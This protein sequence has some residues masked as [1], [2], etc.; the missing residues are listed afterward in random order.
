MAKRN[1]SRSRDT[2]RSHKKTQSQI[3]VV[4]KSTSNRTRARDQK[5][6]RDLKRK[7]RIRRISLGLIGLFLVILIGRTIS[8][9]LNTYKVK[10]YP[11][12]R[13][14]V[15]DSMGSDV[16]IA[17]SEGR[18]LSTAEKVTDFDN[19]YKIIQRNYAV[20]SNNI[21]DFIEF[22]NKYNDFRKK[23][24]I[25]KTDQE[26]L[27][28][29]NQYLDVLDDIRTFIIDKDT[30]DSLFNFH[31][32]QND[33]YRRSV[34]ENPQAVDRYKRLINQSNKRKPSMDISIEKEQILRISLPDFKPD[35]FK[36]DIKKINEALT[37]GQ[38]ITTILLDLSDNDSIDDVYKNKLLEILIHNDYKE[39]N[40]VF[41]RGKLADTTLSSIK[42]SENNYY[43]T[44]HVKNDARKYANDYES[45]NLDDY[46]YYD[47]LSLDIKKD[48]EYSNR[49]IYVLTN[50]NTA[51][52]AI[53]LA[54]IL[55]QNGAYVVKNGFDTTTTYKEVIYNMPSELYV[56]EHS[57]LVLSLNAAYSKNEEDNRYL[58][59][60]QKINSKD[61]IASMLNI[62]N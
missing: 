23:V 32:N 59:Y 55:K 18:S 60:D 54:D 36:D 2:S 21:N 7:Y 11:E 22:T 43:S 40:L 58:T 3:R 13:E 25:S 20:D 56:L 49:N 39:S 51:N 41:Y 62:I 4:D 27:N 29:L 10:G 48:E 44:A 14:E 1:S 37:Q 33:D 8:H 52:E 42:E 38:Q 47:E 46:M 24:Y 35:E 16:F 5:R 45:I 50:A 15:L 34:L 53:K 6:K 30:Y 31:R 12:F 9:A 17:S 28:I 26:Y 19:L 57:G 61:P